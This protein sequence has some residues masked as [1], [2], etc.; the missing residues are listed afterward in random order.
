MRNGGWNEVLVVIS[1]ISVWSMLLYF[2]P[3]G[4]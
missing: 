4:G 1:W 2:I 3:S